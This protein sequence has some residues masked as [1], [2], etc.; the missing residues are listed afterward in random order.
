MD[1][2]CEKYDQL[3][4]ENETEYYKNLATLRKKDDKTF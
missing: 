3:I 2:L 4:I 1:F